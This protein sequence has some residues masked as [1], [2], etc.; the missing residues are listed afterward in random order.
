MRVVDAGTIAHYMFQEKAVGNAAIIDDIVRKVFYAI[1]NI[2]D[3]ARRA[4]LD[5]VRSILDRHIIEA[6]SDPRRAIKC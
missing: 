2:S 1:P 5:E 6:P 4:Q 3:N